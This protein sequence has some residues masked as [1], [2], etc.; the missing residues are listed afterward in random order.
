MKKKDIIC[1]I[2]ARTESTRLPGKILLPGY[3]RPLLLHLVERIKKS[4][5]IKKII[6][7]TTK[8]D[9][10][11]G[12]AHKYKKIIG[13]QFHPESIGTIC[14]KTIFK[15]FLGIINYEDNRN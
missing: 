8:N 2:Q 10:I 11:M 12:I 3:D 15:N 13:L 4:Q 7:A 14:G 9:I 6:I 1:I 5:L